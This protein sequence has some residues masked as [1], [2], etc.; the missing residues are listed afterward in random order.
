MLVMT[1]AGV[2]FGTSDTPPAEP[3]IPVASS[4]R[5]LTERQSVVADAH[6]L[7]VSNLALVER[8][9]AF[10]AHRHRLSADEQEEFGGVV[11]LR[12]VENDYA[13]VR[14]Y[15]GRSS[16]AAYISVVVQ[17]LLLDH[18]TH[19]WGKWHPSAEAKRLGELAVELEKLL[20]RDGRTLEEAYFSLRP[21]NPSIDRDGLR[22]LA[23]SFPP[24]APRKRFVAIDH[25]GGLGVDAQPIPSSE[26]QRISEHVSVAIREFLAG[27]S[28]DDRLVMQLRFDSGMT[29]AD[30][31]RSLHLDQKKLYRRIESHLAALRAMLESR[32]IAAREVA[33][34]IGDRGVV[35]DFG[36][37]EVR[38]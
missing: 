19:L 37:D 13:I 35:F 11:R 27:L 16:F 7:L 4:D 33:D 9:I 21:A 20:L 6:E 3:S 29:V 25:A 22:R 10:V 34:L 5:V 15:E 31:A 17:R 14:R 12:L 32:G 23:D 38:T 8:A 36:L 30:I 2:D 18:R 1:C 24:R 26:Q 28:A